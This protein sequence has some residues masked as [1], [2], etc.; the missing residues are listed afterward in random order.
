MKKE[1]FLSAIGDIEDDYIEEA[2]RYKRP[3][4]RYWL[5][6]GSLAACLIITIFAFAQLWPAEEPAPGNTGGGKSTILSLPKL[7]IDVHHSEKKSGTKRVADASMLNDGS[8]WNERVDVKEMP[9]YENTF[10]TAEAEEPMAVSKDELEERVTMVAANLDAAVEDIEYD[11]ET[12]TTDGE[13][14]QY[15]GE[16][17]AYQATA[18]T[19]QGEIF[20][21]S[22]H[23]TVITF[24]QSVVL[25]E[26]YRFDGSDMSKEDAE[27]ATDYLLQEYG[28]LLSFKNPKQSVT[29]AY[30]E[31]GNFKWIYKG[32]DE[33]ETTEEEIINYN[34][35][36][37]I[38]ETDEEGNLK[39]IILRDNLSGSKELDTY[40][41]INAAAAK[42][43]LKKGSYIAFDDDVKAPDPQN[44]EN[45]N[46]VYLTGKNYA[47][48]LP[49]YA[50][51][52]KSQD[53]QSETSDLA[54]YA[55]YFVPAVKGEYISNM[56]NAS[57]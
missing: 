50:F 6:Y 10:F 5:R 49:Y 52:I 23:N 36:Q 2:A 12:G 21:T 16:E 41:I 56:P 14:K 44:I 48:F 25:P 20:V 39:A 51:D 28:E 15:A 31:N 24:A 7:T 33:G 45:V 42:A 37:M 19:D 54:Q 46:L 26:E 27:K 22:D 8:P 29:A 57:N 38:F 40:P 47:T 55:T 32:Y 11:E 17:G 43:L 9:V 30:D 34:L 4:K 3:A 18:V 53:S 1:D 35:R 13:T